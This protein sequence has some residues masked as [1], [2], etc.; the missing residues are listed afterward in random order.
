MEK[1][2]TLKLLKKLLTLCILAGVSTSANAEKSATLKKV[3]VYHIESLSTKDT[4][5]SARFKRD[6][7]ATI[8]TIEALTKEKIENCGYE[9][10]TK[11]LFYDSSD[12]LQAKES[13]EK[14]NQER[15]WLIVGPARSNHYLLS[16][17]G[18]PNVP[19]ISPLASAEEIST[20]GNLH[21]SLSPTNSQM[22]VAAAIEAA[23]R[24]KQLGA[25]LTFA[26]IISED[27]MA[28]VDFSKQFNLAAKKMKLRNLREFFV[29]GRSPNLA[30]I[31]KS[32]KDISPSFVLIPN[33]SKTSAHILSALGDLDN[34]T[35]YVGGD[36]W[37]DSTFGFIQN[38][39]GL[40]SATGFTVR[41]YPPTPKGIQ[42]FKFGRDVLKSVQNKTNLHMPT[43]SS[44]LAQL[45][46]LEGTM[47]LLC[48]FRPKDKDGFKKLFSGMA[49][50]EFRSPWGV[51]IYNLKQGTITYKSSRKL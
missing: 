26:S 1:E 6:Y 45:R 9:I 8:K 3:L 28:C 34:G 31:K 24:V 32:L 33:Y 46:I 40:D 23:Q 17:K 5:Y 42:Q 36:G 44:A 13:A 51:S 27:C 11:T 38:G 29:S 19:S 7:E 22:A 37:G 50:I 49:N 30:E 35:F 15:A 16:V 47:N 10:E 14:A 18:A 2:T 4:I 25:N 43:S 39:S 48:K 41:G 12:P 21:I 20:L